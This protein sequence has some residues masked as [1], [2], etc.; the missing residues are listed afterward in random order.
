M[1]SSLTID[2][3]YWTPRGRG[4]TTGG[5]IA[6]TSARF[7]PAMPPTCRRTGWCIRS[8]RSVFRLKRPPRRADAK[9]EAEKRPM[10][11]ASKLSGR[12]GST[13]LE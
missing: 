2:L 5:M 4:P 6:E 7:I 10:E 12:L 11:E 3:L 9:E 13:D 8:F 1:A